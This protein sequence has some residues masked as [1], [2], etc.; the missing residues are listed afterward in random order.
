MDDIMHKKLNIG[1]ILNFDERLYR[2][3]LNKNLA[4]T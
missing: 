2:Q 1:P 3:S 4:H